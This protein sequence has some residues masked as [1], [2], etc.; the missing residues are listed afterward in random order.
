MPKTKQPP[1]PFGSL[2]D[3]IQYEINRTDPKIDHFEE[4]PIFE[5]WLFARYP[6]SPSTRHR[7]WSL[8]QAL[9][10]IANTLGKTRFMDLSYNDWE[11][12]FFTINE[13]KAS[14]WQKE[15]YRATANVFFKY[16]V[17]RQFQNQKKP[18]CAIPDRE[19][20]TFTSTGRHFERSS[21]TVAEAKGVLERLSVGITGKIRHITRPELDYF[22]VGLNVTSGIRPGAIVSLNKSFIDLSKRKIEAT[23]EIPGYHK[24][25]HI[26]VPISLFLYKDF[27]NY[28]SRVRGEWVF[29]SPVQSTFPFINTNYFR[30]LCQE[31]ISTWVSKRWHPHSGRSIL[32]TARFL[33][34]CED[35][36]REILIGHVPT[37]VNAQKY[38]WLRDNFE[39][40]RDFFD[41]YDPFLTPQQRAHL[42]NP[43]E[44]WQ[45]YV[46]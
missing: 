42:A 37:G 31:E 23:I 38:L 26:L 24:K 17:K 30:K 40:M 35:S 36:L 11:T 3:V 33:L 28:L 21:I 19:D 41:W 4:W 1:K 18:D 15:R 32:N 14:Q 6:S 45:K 43:F 9:M 12:I 5:R 20:F 2:D 22:I 44:K 29:P 7:Q 27:S 39:A 10:A 34:G 16:L 8:M 13:R 25:K 46:G